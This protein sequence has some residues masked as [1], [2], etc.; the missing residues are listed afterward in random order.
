M[1]LY[2]LGIVLVVLGLAGLFAG[3]VYTIVLVPVGVIVLV[4]AVA[5]GEFSRRS[6]ARAGG[7]TG[8]SQEREA[9][10][11]LPTSHPPDPSHVR[12]SPEGLADARRA[13]Q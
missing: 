2:M 6:Q 1:W 8:P 4:S 13:Q 7:S 5:M 11:P 3:G 10:K 9:E 12:T